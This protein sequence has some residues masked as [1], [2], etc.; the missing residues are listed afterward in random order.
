MNYETRWREAG[1]DGWALTGFLALLGA[2]PF[3]TF[4]AGIAQ[5]YR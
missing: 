4:V 5:A 1:W 3:W 2:A